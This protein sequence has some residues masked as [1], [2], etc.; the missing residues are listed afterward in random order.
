MFNDVADRLHPIVQVSKVY[1]IS[2]GQV[3]TANR[4]YTSIDHEY[5]LTFDNNT[6][7]QLCEEEGGIPGIRYNFIQI[8]DIKECGKDALIGMSIYLYL[9]RNQSILATNQFISL[10]LLSNHSDV[11][12]V[13]T[14]TQ[15]AATIVTKTTKKDLLKRNVTLLDGSLHTIELTFWGATAENPGWNEGDHPILALKG[16]RVSDFNGK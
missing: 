3:K 4:K 7:M 2:K 10:R 8:S 12:G 11:L 1:L 16:V 5:E 15:P 9:S 14:E 6:I 13:V